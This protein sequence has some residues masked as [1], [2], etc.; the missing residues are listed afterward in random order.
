MPRKTNTVTSIVARTCSKR[1]V[2]GMPSP[3]QKFASK[4]SALKAPIRMTM[5]TRIGTI[6]ATV[7]TELMKAARLT[8]LRI[9]K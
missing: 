1:L 3:L 5:K 2:C 8:P 4:R 9:M 7:T 6:L